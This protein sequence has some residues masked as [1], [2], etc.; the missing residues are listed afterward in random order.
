M[1][2]EGVG[3]KEVET[4]RNKA[5]LAADGGGM[6]LLRVL[7][8]AEAHHTANGR[9]ERLQRTQETILDLVTCLWCRANGPWANRCAAFHTL[10]T[11]H[12][13][14]GTHRRVV[15]A[16]VY[17]NDLLRGLTTV[18]SFQRFFS[19]SKILMPAT[20]QTCPCPFLPAG[21][22]VVWLLRCVCIQGF[23]SLA[24]FYMFIMKVTAP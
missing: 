10:P 23:S 13:T 12:S 11:S 4:E 8:S 6:C 15:Q 3:Q 21:Y 7:L 16:V 18:S 9:C 2:D 5:Q 22:K 20:S 19:L 24:C 17:L 1:R 14:T